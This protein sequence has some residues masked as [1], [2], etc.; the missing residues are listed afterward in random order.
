CSKYSQ[1]KFEMEDG[2]YAS[3]SDGFITV[4]MH[5]WRRLMGVMLATAIIVTAIFAVS[6]LALLRKSPQSQTTAK[7]ENRT[8]MTRKENDVP[9]AK[10][11]SS[12]VLRLMSDQLQNTTLNEMMVKSSGP[13]NV[14]VRNET[15]VGAPV[16]PMNGSG[17]WIHR[18]DLSTAAGNSNNE[19][20]T[21]KT[22][23]EILATKLPPLLLA[24]T[25]LTKTTTGHLAAETTFLT[26][27]RHRPNYDENA[28]T[29]VT[30]ATT[31]EPSPLTLES[32]DAAAIYN[33]SIGSK[34]YGTAQVT[35]SSKT[36][37][38]AL[39]L[40][41]F[42]MQRST[43]PTV[44]DT[45]TNRAKNQQFSGLSFRTN[46]IERRLRSNVR[47]HLRRRRLQQR[48]RELFQR[49]Q[50]PRVTSAPIT[51]M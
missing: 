33:T 28:T 41:T 14:S 44:S 9:L 2:N 26:P 22:S 48:L 18:W 37:Q 24:S 4:R 35:T 36:M 1:S 17:N 23:P 32:D 11:K 7:E 42:V 45:E 12:L 31:I 40:S 8:P 19:V 34:I 15:T 5:R 30:G 46:Q 10:S 16:A 47:N 38:A 13:I 27:K 50:S 21:S 49:Q 25:P 3:L 20:F 51:D 6:V 29:M 43:S 39:L